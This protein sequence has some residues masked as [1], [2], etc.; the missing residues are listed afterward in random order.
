L[1][2]IVEAAADKLPAPRKRQTGGKKSEKTDYMGRWRLR[3]RR[4]SGSPTDPEV[5]VCVLRIDRDAI[6]SF[7][8]FAAR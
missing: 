4:T 2:N 3:R 6:F 5:R 1:F 7:L 8:M